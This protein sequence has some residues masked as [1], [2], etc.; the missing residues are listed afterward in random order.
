MRILLRLL[1]RL[2]FGYRAYNVSVLTAPGPVLLIPNHLSWIDWL[3]LAVCLDDDWRF[4]TSSTTAQTSWVHRW[5]MINRH[6][7]P[8]DTNSPYAV[9]RMAEFLQAGGRLVLFAEG[10]LSRTGTLMKLFDGTGFLLFKTHAKVITCYLRG[11]QRLPYSPHPGWKTCFPRVTAHFSEV[12]TPPHLQH[13]STAQART[14]STDW[15]RDALVNQQ[16]DVEMKFGPE[17]VLAAIAETA[18]QRPRQII[19]EDFSRQK[20]SY[21]RLLVGVDV[22]AQ[23]WGKILSSDNGRT[24]VLLPNVNAMPVTLLSLWAAEKVPAILNYSTG[25]TIMLSCVQLEIGRAHV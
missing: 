22:L 24:G 15:L 25:P 19:L 17:N 5:L 12:L 2:L 11:A 16:F 8:I 23:Q 7:F 3:F 18:R 4:V 1:L 21:R 6:T 20:L 9:K 14:L 13:L 10:R